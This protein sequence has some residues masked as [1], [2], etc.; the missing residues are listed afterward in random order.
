MA[1]KV[2]SKQDKQAILDELA[3]ELPLVTDK[4]YEVKTTPIASGSLTLDLAIGIGGYP[5][6][7]IVNV[8]GP[9]AGGKSLISMMAI[10]QCQREGGVAIVWDAERSYSRNLDW[11][12][13]NG[14]DTSKIRFIRLRAT[15]GAEL[16]FDTIEKVLTRNAADLIIIDSLPSLVP[17]KAMDKDVTEQVVVA[18]R[19][20]MLSYVM[21]RMAAYADESKCCLM[22]IDQMRK[23]IGG[24]MYGPTEKETSILSVIHHSNIRL[25]VNMVSKSM[26]LENDIPVS[27][28]VRVKVVKNKVAAPFRQAEFEINYRKGVDNASEVA[29][30]LIAAGKIEQQGAWFFYGKD[31]FQGMDKLVAHFKVPEIYAKSVAEVKALT[32]VNAFGVKKSEGEKANAQEELEV[33]DEE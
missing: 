4:D 26:K 9:P 10:A 21:P 20:G 30:I 1:A 12:R 32:N 27:H 31:K 11:M 22:L 5:R 16:G 19:A 23:N 29:D 8:F 17:Q 3:G 13:V 33:S 7:S 28:R 15:Q 2:L 24:G 6:G 25:Q 14:I 18:A